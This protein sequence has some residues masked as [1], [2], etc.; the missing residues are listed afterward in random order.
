MHPLRLVEPEITGVL[1]DL[2]RIVRVLR[3]S[4]RA[5]Q[6][7]LGVTGAQL[8]VLNVLS[9]E[10]SLSTNELAR[11][12]LTHQSTV[13]VV[14][15]RLVTRGLVSRA[16]S[17]T[18]ARSVELALTARGRA[19]L[20]KAPGAAQEELIAGIERLSPAK[21]GALASALR[22]L[23]VT[24]RLADE[25]PSMFFEDEEPTPSRK[26]PRARRRS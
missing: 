18:D 1:D 7:K 19:L 12:T 3:Q 21:R 20:R 15:K 25:E 6:Q 26:K 4:S 22:E 10:T 24:M 16:T 23:V 13:S 14:V 11:R 8:F 9:T 17:K 5:A 2:R